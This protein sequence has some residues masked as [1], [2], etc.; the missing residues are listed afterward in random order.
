MYIAAIRVNSSST[1]SNMI[2]PLATSDIHSKPDN[3]KVHS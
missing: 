1:S 2:L 3:N